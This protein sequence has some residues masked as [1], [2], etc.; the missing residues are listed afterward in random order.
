MET[1]PDSSA[2][3]ASGSSISQRFTRGEDS[4]GKRIRYKTAKAR[5]SEEASASSRKPPRAV[6]K[7]SD[8]PAKKTREISSKKLIIGTPTK[9]STKTPIITS[10]Q[11]PIITP[12]RTPNRTPSRLTSNPVRRQ[13]LVD[14]DDDMFWEACDSNSP[15]ASQGLSVDAEMV[16]MESSPPTPTI[17]EIIMS[18]SNP[19]YDN[20]A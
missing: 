20:F 15:S 8:A 4:E 2:T 5:A 6:V 18:N 13:V 1:A 19:K 11:T 17:L 3:S 7:P 14:P 12:T 16:L 9:T 10:N